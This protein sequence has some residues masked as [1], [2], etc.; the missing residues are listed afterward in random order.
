MT[1]QVTLRRARGGSLSLIGE[2]ARMARRS[3]AR[4]PA[5]RF[6]KYRDDPFGFCRDVLGFEPW[7]A[8]REVGQALVRHD[9]V[10]NTTGRAVGKSRNGAGLA[11]WFISTRGPGARV[12]ATAPTAKQVNEILWSE[13]R[14]LYSEAKIP[15]GGT[16]AKLATT[17]L[18]F[19]DGRSV[20][21]MTAETPEAFAGIR[22][23]EMLVIVDEASGVSDD[24][25]EA[26]IGNL[27]GGGKLLLLGNPT[28]SVGFFRESLRGERFTVVHT[29]STSSPNVVAGEEIIKGLA[30]REWVEDRKREW[31]ETSALYRIH[32]LGEV[33]EAAEGQLFE[34]AMLD[35]ARARWSATPATGRLVIGVDPAG[36][37]GEGDESAFCVRRGKKVLRITTRRGLS[38]EGHLAEILG[39]IAELRGD[40]RER[41]LVILDRD[42]HI[43]AKVYGV[44][45]AYR[46]QHEA[47]FSLYGVRGGERARRNP[48]AVDRVR[49]EV[50]LALADAFRDGLTIPEDV[51]LD[52]ELCAVKTER[53]IS[54]RTKVTAKDDLRRELGRSPDRADALTLACFELPDWAASHT[55][56]A[57][58]AQRTRMLDPYVG[59]QT[60]NAAFDPYAGAD[61]WG[62][63][64]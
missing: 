6:E 7:D 46:S 31:G 64:R 52:R 34:K 15:L 22:A 28:R 24:I 60:S 42:G 29:P 17:G 43:G 26:L 49:D 4:Q 44:V 20:F 39:S 53:H 62:G 18:R 47:T 14:R 37:G 48:L 33:V 40:S 51:R 25:F 59:Q 23:P 13:I 35:D 58:T 56:P 19:D 54:G 27:A 9:A 32:V 1:S 38:E 2:L 11:L 21:G 57:D 8:Q 36:P 63:N 55:Q 16:I 3:A 30:T 61:A 12:I 10:S 50:W 41:P 5:T 45:S